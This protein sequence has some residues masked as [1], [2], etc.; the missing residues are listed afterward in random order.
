MKE[1]LYPL[2]FIPIVSLKPWGGTA[3]AKV[4]GKK[5]TDN[6][7]NS[8]RVCSQENAPIGESWELSNIG[9]QN[10]IIGNG[11]LKGRT[12]DEIMQAFQK[13]VVGEKAF[14]RYGTQFPLLIKFLNIEGKLSVQVH[15]DDKI[16]AERYN[17]L[18]K[19][20]VWYIL[21][22]KADAKV[23]MGFNRDVSPEEFSQAC[24]SGTAGNLL[25]IIYPK[26]GDVIFIKP[27][28]VHSAEGGILLCEIQESSDIT[29][30]LYDWGRENDPATA[31]RMNLD[32]AMDIIDFKKH[33]PAD[34]FT[35]GTGNGLP[36]T[37]IADCPQFTVN[38][39]VIDNITHIRTEERN[40]FLV[41]S[42]IKGKVSLEMKEE[43]GGTEKYSLEH[44]DT[45]LIPAECPRFSISPIEDNSELL[46]SLVP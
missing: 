15:P 35:S 14:K 17:S 18:G 37:C 33:D 12:I 4:L 5:F 9:G 7:E 24:K 38:H 30:R 41:Y 28:T 42:C 19:T 36:A 27:G 23:Y 29:L 22:A 13:R 25:N 40:C 11:Y 1:E 26:K 20:E 8:Q 45:I 44:G 32:E 16:A 34:Y 6:N 31:R 46:E 3:L 21:D 43:N 39:L 2:K 10:S